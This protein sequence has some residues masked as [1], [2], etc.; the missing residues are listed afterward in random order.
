VVRAA[1]PSPAP[2]AAVTT[3]A[4]PG[5]AGEPPRWAI[6]AVVTTALEQGTDGDDTIGGAIGVRRFLP[7][8]LA[9]R[10]GLAF[11]LTERDDPDITTRA[12][13]GSLGLAWAAASFG[14]PGHFGAGVRA[15][16]LFMRHSVRDSQAPGAGDRIYWSAGVDALAEVGLGLSRGTML[17]VA[18]G[19][20]EL[21]TEATVTV[22]GEDAAT[23]PRARVLLELGVL[24]RF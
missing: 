6:D 13:G 4:E 8:R 9:L 19:L 14:R 16:G 7:L 17:M 23:L 11:R 12:L 1:P 2:A 21:F 18:A 10:A 5:E 3:P 22:P 24:A 20:E 15:D